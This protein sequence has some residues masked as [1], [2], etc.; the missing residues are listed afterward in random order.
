M[1][2]KVVE[3]NG[4]TRVL[5]DLK[6]EIEAAKLDPYSNVEQTSEF[7][8]YM[9]YVDAIRVAKGS[10]LDVRP[11]VEAFKAYVPLHPLNAIFVLPIL[12]LS[13]EYG[14]DLSWYPQPDCLADPATLINT[15]QGES[16]P[17]GGGAD[18]DPPAGKK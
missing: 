4:V 13:T 8:Y 1:A 14:V 6:G 18:A 15:V 3:L 10:G 9:A 16:V 17:E 5:V 11:L 7:A 12:D 2:A